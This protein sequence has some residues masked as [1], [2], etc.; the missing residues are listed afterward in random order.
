[1]EEVEKNFGVVQGEFGYT[2][3]GTKG[4]KAKGETHQPLPLQDGGVRQLQDGACINE[5]QISNLSKKEQEELSQVVG[6]V[7]RTNH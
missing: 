1:L 2:S 4:A 3:K 7:Q 6:V 5:S